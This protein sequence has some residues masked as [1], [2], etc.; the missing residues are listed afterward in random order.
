VPKSRLIHF[1]SAAELLD[2]FGLPKD[3][4]T[5]RRLIDGFQ[6]IFGA[7]IFFGTEEQSKASTVF[8][9]EGFR[10]FGPTGG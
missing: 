3:G 7:T 5:Y 10:F 6:R 9:V 1:S 2:T 4:K 8:D